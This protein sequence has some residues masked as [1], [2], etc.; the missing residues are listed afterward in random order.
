MAF[1][2]GAGVSAVYL[3]ADEDFEQGGVDM[4][5]EAEAFEDGQRLRELHA[6]LVW[7]VLGRERFEDI[8]NAHYPCLPAHVFAPQA[9]RVAFAV[10]PFVV[11]T[12]IFRNV[13]EVSRPG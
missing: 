1:E 8:G 6:F 13:F 12:G 9:F 3:P 10:H 4:A 5:V 2:V 11:T 7:P